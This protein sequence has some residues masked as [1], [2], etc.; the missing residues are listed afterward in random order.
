[1][2]LGER[3]SRK[4]EGK[5]S[6]R[7]SWFGRNLSASAFGVSSVWMKIVRAAGGV[8]RRAGCPC[9]VNVGLCRLLEEEMGVARVASE[10]HRCD[11][12]SLW[13]MGV[14]LE[15]FGRGSAL[16]SVRI[17][18]LLAIIGCGIKSL[19]EYDQGKYVAQEVKLSC[20]C[21]E[22]GTFQSSSVL[23]SPYLSGNARMPKFGPISRAPIV[24][25]SIND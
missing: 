19:G 15:G 21:T 10:K 12:A 3:Y 17:A 13:Q 23:A 25:P 22:S 8:C 9:G 7:T 18:D 4:G 6:G 2:D 14:L 1:V 20:C 24:V 5:L 16:V 11:V